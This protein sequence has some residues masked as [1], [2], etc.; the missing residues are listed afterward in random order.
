MGSDSSHGVVDNWGNLGNVE[1]VAEL[2]IS[3]VENSFSVGTF[4]GLGD[5]VIGLEC[6]L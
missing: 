6:V 5:V 2:E 3:I 1:V 4:L